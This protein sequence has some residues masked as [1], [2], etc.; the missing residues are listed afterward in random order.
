MPATLAPG[1]ARV[2][3]KYTG[4]LTDQRRG[5]NL[6]KATNRR[7]AVTQVEATDAGTRRTQAASC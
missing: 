7:Y 6:S 2:R 5:F 1:P 4:R 3:N